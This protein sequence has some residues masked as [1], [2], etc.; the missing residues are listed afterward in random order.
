VEVGL[1][2]II[3]WGMEI[4]NMKGRLYIGTNNNEKRNNYTKD[5]NRI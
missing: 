2:A 3:L 1:V 4:H 5:K